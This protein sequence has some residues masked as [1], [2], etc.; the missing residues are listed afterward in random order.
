MTEPV[1]SIG[2]YGGSFDP[3][4]FGHLRT[5]LEVYQQLALDELRFIPS[6]DPPHKAG[7]RASA[8]DRIKMLEHAIAR[9][10]GL[11]IDPREIERRKTS[12]T[13][14]TLLEMRS[15]Y[16]LAE[17]T[18]VV[19]TDQFSV[20]DTWHRWEE[21]LSIVKLA[22]MER[23]GEVLSDFGNSLLEGEFAAK[24]ALCQVTQLDISSTRIRSE[25]QQEA[26]IQ[27]LVPYAVRQYIVSNNLYL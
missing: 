15:E 22:V 26:D 12:Y 9:C 3:V 24:I 8:P 14:D 5:A 7:P 16:P 2:V 10:P 23:P 18:L 27:F 11:I 17:L 6:G 13:I 19:G 25:L 4:H 20:F 21:I 1:G